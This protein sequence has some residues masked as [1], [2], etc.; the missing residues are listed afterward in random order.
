MKPLFVTAMCV[1][2][3]A[4]TGCEK[5]SNNT[6]KTEPADATG[7]V[8]AWELRTGYGG[9]TLPNTSP[10]HAP[11][12][13]RIWVFT[14]T[15]YTMYGQGQVLNTGPYQ[16]TKDIAPA[17]GTVL[18]AIVMPQN[19]NLKLHYQFVRDTLVLYNSVIAA[20]GTIEKYVPV[21]PPVGTAK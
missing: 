19:G 18:D 9:F 7:L 3:L 10:N 8:G 4:F 12:N 11:G 21:Q 17:T 20:D 14:D 1:A 5:S 6:E 15:S 2:M 13:G 16:R